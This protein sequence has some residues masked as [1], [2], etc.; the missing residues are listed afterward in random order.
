[1]EFKKDK[2]GNEYVVL[3]DGTEIGANLF[4]AIYKRKTLIG[5]KFGRL[6]VVRIIGR[7]HGYKN[8]EC[9]CD[10]GKITTA[11]AQALSGNKK[12][13][14]GCLHSEISKKTMHKTMKKYNEFEFEGNICKIIVGKEKALIDLE[15]YEK[16]KYHRWYKNANG[17]ICASIDNKNI[18]LHLWI[19]ENIE[20][21]KV[22]DHRDRNKLNN[23]SCNLIQVEESVNL[24]N[25]KISD[26]NKSGFVGVRFVEKRNT[27]ESYISFKNKR[28]FLGYFK[29]KNEAVKVRKKAELFYYGFNPN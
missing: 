20:K 15:K 21:N 27:W 11:T 13:S 23:T 8:Y 17:Y 4:W 25:R 26:K 29:N 22:V 14:C 12:Q 10:C 7:K 18:Y 2:I 24:F 3:N 1:M 5:K 9:V 16:C 28:I 19:T 6:K